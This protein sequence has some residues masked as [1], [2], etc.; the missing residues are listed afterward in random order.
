MPLAQLTIV[1]KNQKHFILNINYQ[2]PTNYLDDIDFEVE[3]V[4]SLW[5]EKE[6]N[7]DKVSYEYWLNYKDQIQY[8]IELEQNFIGEPLK[9]DFYESTYI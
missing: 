1:N 7:G 4:Y 2:C 6:F 5:F 8:A 9:Q 3:S